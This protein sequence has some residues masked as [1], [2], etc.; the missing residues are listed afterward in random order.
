MR[1]FIRHPSGVPIEIR[2]QGRG[3]QHLR[4]MSNVSLGGLAFE[5]EEYLEKGVLLAVRIPLVNPVFEG[6]GRVAWCRKKNGDFEVGI[7]F[8]NEQD[9]FTVRM[10]EQVCHI[11]HY[12]NEVRTMEG[13]ELTR[14]AAAREWIAKY[15]AQF[16]KLG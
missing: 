4:Q 10:V 15:A 12:R 9:A 16:P 13:R 6:T 14:E 11:E 1:D 2:T 5:S 7:Q 3:G 8:T